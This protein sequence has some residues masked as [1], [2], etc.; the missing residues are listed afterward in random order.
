MELSMRSGFYIV[1]FVFVTAMQTGFGAA[2]TNHSSLRPP[3]AFSSISDLGERSRAIFA[4]V[5]KVL[6]HPRCLNCHPAGD[7]PTQE[8]DVHPHKPFVL[9]DVPCVT[10]HTDRNFTLHERASYQSIP[11][12]PHWMMA[13]IEM[14]WQGKSIGEICHN[15]K[16]AIAT[17]G[18]IW[19]CCTNISLTMTWW[20]GDG[21]RAPVASPLPAA[22]RCSAS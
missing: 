4:E 20:L 19:R 16:I 6:T 12:H 14:A 3:S 11:G 21:S 1:L 7:R 9:R 8:N 2:Q 13:P 22:K 10:C 5:A 15:S 17:A 18:A